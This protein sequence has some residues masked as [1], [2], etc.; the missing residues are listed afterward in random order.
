[1]IV[2]SRDGVKTGVLLGTQKLADGA[3]G[4]RRWGASPELGGAE[5]WPGRSR[6][7]GARGWARA[8][9][10]ESVPGEGAGAGPGHG[11]PRRGPSTAG[12]WPA[13][14]RSPVKQQADQQLEN[15]MWKG[16]DRSP[17]RRWGPP[18]LKGV[19]L[20]RDR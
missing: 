10:R 18:R 13:C 20:N 5:Q 4:G 9:E 1:M 7:K 6:R 15:N 11:C 19:Y 2:H 16:Y 17:G 3:G 8:A 12:M 14:C